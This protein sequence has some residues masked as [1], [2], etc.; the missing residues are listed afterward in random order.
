MNILYIEDDKNLAL[1]V[2]NKLKS[3]YNI[4]I[5]ITG[6]AAMQ[7]IEVKEYDLLILDYYLPDTDGLKICKKIRRINKITPILFFTINENKSNIIEALDAGADDYLTKPFIYEELEA[8]IRALTRR[9]IKDN[10]GK[11]LKIG[12]LSVS[13]TDPCAFFKNHIVK[14][15]RQEYLLLKY[16][17]FNKNRIVSRTE[18]YEHVWGQDS[19]YNSNTIDVHI[20]RLRNK[21]KPLGA[22][23]YIK[24]VYGSGYKINNE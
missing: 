10:E 8:R 22:D 19:Y 3:K 16:L 24:S 11:I 17:G 15:P 13:L 7:K 12:D 20:R 2:K 21:L 14:L 6:D 4:D 5:A 1:T 9:N 18:L 23:N